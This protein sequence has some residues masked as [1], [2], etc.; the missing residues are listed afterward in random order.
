VRLEESKLAL[1]GAEQDVARLTALLD[2]ATIQLSRFTLRAP[3]SGTITLRSVDPGQQVDTT[4]PLFTLADT[5]ELL[6]EADVDETYA[7]RIAP[8]QEAVAQL[9]GSR[10]TLAGKVIFV[11][12]RVNPATGGLAVKIG[13]DDL[14][15]APIG[16]TV[17]ANIVVGREEALTV[18]R[19]AL[20][21]DAVFRLIGGHAV[22]TPVT[23]TDWPAP[24]LIVTDGLVAGDKVISDSTGLTDGLDVIADM[25]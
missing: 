24:R 5:G 23:V 6:V 21:G 15:R 8:G 19:T 12:P 3:I 17:T 11:S 22:L 13:L 16:L 1:E 14:L 25:P 18:P 4:T 9:V 2:Q 7:T 20:R 10:S